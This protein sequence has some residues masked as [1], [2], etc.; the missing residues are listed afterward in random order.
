MVS[1]VLLTNLP[2]RY[3]QNVNRQV[4][5]RG[6]KFTVLSVKNLLISFIA[7]PMLLQWSD[8]KA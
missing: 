6:K 1:P 5:E 4:C 2:D 8:T 7:L 3:F